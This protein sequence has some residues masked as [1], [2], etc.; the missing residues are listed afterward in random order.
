MV[1]MSDDGA[2]A[3]IRIPSM[4]ISRRD[5]QRLLEYIIKE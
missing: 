5:G 2:G 1:N 3:G 4:I